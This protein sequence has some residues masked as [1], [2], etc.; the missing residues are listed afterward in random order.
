MKAV[1]RL[2]LMARSRGSRQVIMAI[3]AARCRTMLWAA[4]LM[5]P[6]SALTAK[7]CRSEDFTVT[8]RH[9][10][11]TASKREMSHG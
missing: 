3:P 10:T 5:T 8:A 6:S 9:N 7:S 1:L 2:V 4:V 11:A